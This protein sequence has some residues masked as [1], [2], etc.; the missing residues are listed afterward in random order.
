MLILVL[1]IGGRGGKSRK[2]F[3]NF[4]IQIFNLKVIFEVKNDGYLPQKI[5]Y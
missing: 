2:S 3:R 1:L 4:F 5:I